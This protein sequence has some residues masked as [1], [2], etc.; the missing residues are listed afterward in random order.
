[1][2]ANAAI[3]KVKE[4]YRRLHQ[5][6]KY[7]YRRTPHMLLKN[8]CVRV[9]GINHNCRRVIRTV[10]SPNS[11]E[12]PH[13]STRL[14]R[15]F[16][17]GRE[18]SSGSFVTGSRNAR[19]LIL[20]PYH[21]VPGRPWSKPLTIFERDPSLRSAGP[22]LCQRQNWVENVMVMIRNPPP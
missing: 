12:R 5:N 10:I 15:L 13:R 22:A 21:R 2:P 11:Q 14:E 20:L 6:N 9:H 19:L 4:R 1:M 18:E 8:I 3:N 17:K 16:D 7:E